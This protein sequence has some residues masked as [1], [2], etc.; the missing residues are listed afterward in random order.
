[1]TRSHSLVTRLTQL[2]RWRNLRW[3][4]ALTALP[5]LWACNSH[6]LEQPIPQPTQQSDLYY[7]VNPIRDVDILFMID[8]S[9]SMATKQN[10]LARNFP[11]FIAELQKIPG[12]TGQPALPNVRIG[13]VSSDMGGAGSNASNCGTRPGGD[14]GIF[15]VLPG[16]GLDVTRQRYLES[17]DSG[18]TN[19]FT[20]NLADVFSCMAKLGDVGC[21]FEHQLQATRLALYP[22]AN[23]N[24]AENA[25]FLRPNAYL[26]VILIT[27]EDDCSAPPDTH[28]FEADLPGQSASLR[29][30]IKGHLCNGKE[31]PVG[32][33]TAPIID[34]KSNEQGQLISVAEVVGNIKNLKPG[35]AD[36]IVVA[37]ITG[38]AGDGKYKIGKV[39]DVD[40]GMDV[41]DYLPGCS[42]PGDPEATATPA[43]RV[44]EFVDG[45]G[46]NGSIHNICMD[47]FSPAMK[48][49]GEKLKAI[50]ST[51]CI[52][53]PLVDKEPKVDG[54]Q[55]DC[56]VSDRKTQ[57]GGIVDLPIPQCGP[58]KSPPCWSLTKTPSC[59]ASGFKIDVDRGGKMADP[60][61]QQVIKCLTCPDPKDP[62]CAVR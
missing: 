60:G 56:Q 52:E 36:R 3:A 41:F 1:M 16:C 37:A 43:I 19:N 14:R 45:F 44:K 6:P 31:P 4:G 15:Q 57:S 59:L 40:T 48:K 12:P 34:C 10:R 5:A 20:G 22:T 46:D 13:I 49:I 38:S 25:G 26:A 21:G 28:L 30:A 8:N 32:D 27:D 9:P 47:D 17:K 24:L 54:L 61:T 51:T 62:R 29:C 7:D 55:A 50:I 39:K 58:G 53:A 42:F 2:V 23:V 33:F 11:S 18:K 35:R